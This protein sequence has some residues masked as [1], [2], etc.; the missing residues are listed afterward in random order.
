MTMA[1][2]SMAAEG[3]AWIRKPSLAVH[4]QRFQRWV[5]RTHL[6]R[7]GERLVS[8]LAP[9]LEGRLETGDLLVVGE[10]I[11]AIAEG[12]AVLLRSVRPR[13]LARV[14]SRRVRPLGYG[15][16]L[17]RP[18]TME[19]AMREVGPWRIV[20]AAAVAAVT[21]MAGRSGDFYRL[22]GR[23]VAAIDG[24]GP[25]TIAPYHRY[26]VLAPEHPRE[27]ARQLARRFRVGVAIVDVNDV[28]SEVLAESPG[29]DPRL[30]RA[31]MQDNPMGQGAQRTPLAVLRP[32]AVRT[33]SA[34]WPSAPYP[35]GGDWPVV[36]G[37]GVGVTAA[38][39]AWESP[40][41]RAG[42]PR[43]NGQG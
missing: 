5:V 24:P 23:R 28:G 1:G 32:T 18:E 34:S 35:L 43:Y 22:A 29:V 39:T 40:A 7:P 6:I 9:Y 33:P 21:R 8:A 27:V 14:L 42:D 12:R 31:L 4:G 30:V 20:L 19:M 25:S 3:E 17:R 2:S 37:A 38:S 16:G 13:W 41:L 15:L 10:K 11:V 26:I 36:A